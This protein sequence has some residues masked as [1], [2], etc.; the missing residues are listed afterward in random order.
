[1]LARAFRLFHTVRHLKVI[2]VT[3]RIAS[4]LRQ[5]RIDDRPAPGRRP[6]GQEWILPPWR[7]T[8]L[9]SPTCATFLNVSREIRSA[10]DWNR[11]DWPR[12]WLYNLH[13]FDDMDAAGSGDRAA[14]LN[15]WMRRWIKENPPGYGVGWEPYCLSLRI[16]N[17][18]RWAWRGHELPAEAIH[19][20]AIQTRA[21]ADQIEVHLL[22]NHLLANAKA[23]AFAGVFFEGDEADAWLAKGSRIISAEL[24]EQVLP[25][26]GHFERSPM[27]HGVILSDVLDL[28]ALARLSRGRV[29]PALVEQL[30]DVAERMTTWALTMRHADGEIAF[31]ND[32]AQGI[33]PSPETLASMAR[34]LAVEVR[35]PD[36]SGQHLAPSGYCIFNRGAGRLI[37]D[38]APIGPDYIPGHAH[39]DTLSFE[40]SLGA[41]RV[42]VNTG[43]SEYSDSRI[44][45]FERSTAAHNTVV[46]DG[47]NSSDVWGAFRVGRRARVCRADI[48]ESDRQVVVVAEHTG[49]RRW[50]RRRA[51]ERTWKMQAGELSISDALR[52][53]WRCASSYWHFAPGVDL[54]QTGV[55]MFH[56]KAGPRTRFTLRT[57]G[58]VPR[59]EPAYW[60]PAFGVRIP[61]QVLVLD[62]EDDA[63]GIAL[64]WTESD[65]T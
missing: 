32:A 13:Y 2:Q 35:T 20:L 64:R 52:G 28:I 6:L 12:L 11:A 46:I 44:R 1:M 8:S 39:A 56:G 38:L 54:E 19:S 36:P 27:Y 29:R 53:E 50:G 18:C 7:E 47:E 33:A 61:T 31:F 10:E 23:L 22:G 43:T 57:S 60:A 55:G 5:L 9:I 3:G 59:L 65:Q 51:H 25:D 58:G 45:H 14:F 17:W 37:C 41:N 49:Y 42:F 4:H 15:D 40:L 24:A 63:S 21:L 62:I 16:V 34:A 48:L 30:Q 26:G